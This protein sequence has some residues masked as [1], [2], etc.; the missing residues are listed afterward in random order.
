VASRNIKWL[1][2][3]MSLVTVATL[4]AAPTV[5][6]SNA[7]ISQ[8]LS[9]Y[10][11]VGKACESEVGLLNG[12]TDPALAKVAA[13]ILKPPDL[14]YPL[15]LPPG[16]KSLPAVP[17]AIFMC[18]TGFLCVTLVRDRKTWLAGIA[19]LLWAGQTGFAAL[20]QAASHLI[21]RRQ[22]SR[23]SQQQ[24]RS[25]ALQERASRL[26]SDLEGT[27]YISLLHHL[28]GIPS[29]LRNTQYAI[30]NTR[31]EIRTTNIAA[32]NSVYT[33]L[34]QA[35]NCLPLEVRQFTCFSPAFIF[36]NIPRGPPTLA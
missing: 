6:D 26:R 2:A 35:F 7:R 12:A 34:I 28:E 25:S 36:E 23:Y 1:V 33:Y 14:T 8:A 13:D 21:E 31:H 20:P 27:E 30:R 15:T 3:L 16:T 10:S 19:F 29:T 32:V 17:A 18:L 22:F 4:H 24:Y 11:D 5:G 9:P